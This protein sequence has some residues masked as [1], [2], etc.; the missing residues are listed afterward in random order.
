MSTRINVDGQMGTEEDRLLSPLD[1]GFLFGASVY[2]TIP[3]L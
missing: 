2:E 3:H 1:Q